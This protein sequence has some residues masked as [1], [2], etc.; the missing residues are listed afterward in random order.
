[1]HSPGWF[2]RILLLGLIMCVPVLNFFVIGYAM[3]WA[4][5]LFCGQVEQLPQK[6]FAEGNFT[7][8]CFG[9]VVTLVYGLVGAAVSGIVGWIPILGIVVFTAVSIFLNMLLALALMRVAISNRIG[10][11]FDLK[12]IWATLKS[13]PGELFVVSFIPSLII[14]KPQ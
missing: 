14:G 13:K 6:I 10:T 8:G 7:L 4:K 12:E 11:A 5:Q 3:R 9:F 2:G 1:M